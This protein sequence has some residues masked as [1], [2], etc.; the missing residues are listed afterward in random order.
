MSRIAPNNAARWR[1]KVRAISGVLPL[2]VW[3]AAAFLITFYVLPVMQMLLL[4]LLEP[5]PGLGNYRELF[6]SAVYARVLWN[7]FEISAQV[8][9]LCL[10]LGY[11][12]A[13]LLA[14]ASRRVANLLL[15]F[16]MIPF[17]TSMLVRTYAWI[18][19]LG[20]QGI[21]NTVLL[22]SGIIE[23]PL[24]LLYNRFGVL[25]G[26]VHVLLPYMILILYS[27]MRGIDPRLVHAAESLAAPPFT[28]F[29]RVYLPLSMPGVFCGCI[30]VFVMCLAFFIT[31]AMLGS[32]RETM[33]ANM[34]A[35]QVGVLNWGLG[36]ALS[37]ILLVLSLVGLFMVNRFVGGLAIVGGD[38][39]KTRIANRRV[40]ENIL[41]HTLDRLVDPVWRFVPAV[42]GAGVLAFLIVP[43]FVMLPLSVN[44]LTYFVFPPAGFTFHWYV[45][46]FTSADWME[47][48]CNSVLIALATAFL[49][50]VLAAPAALGITRS[51]SRAAAFLYGLIISPMIVPSIIVAISVGF[52][53]SQLGLIGT[54]VAVVLGHMIGALPLATVVLVSA[55]TNFDPNLERAS[56]SLAAGHLRTM[57]RVIL[58]A[59]RPAVLTGAF[60]A[61]L[62]S[63]DEL[64]IALFVSGMR[65]RTLPKKMWDSLQEIDPT[66]AAVSTILVAV[67][68][69]LV[70]LIQLLQ[71]MLQVRK[72]RRLPHA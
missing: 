24:R 1:A 57:L 30:L 16:V 4:S 53:F 60:F 19:L 41:T 59:I 58:P 29:R 3:P 52:V 46:Y 50:M 23:E 39:S 70:L 44:P 72:S 63:F 5:R 28:A 32:P 49:T 67:T 42:V 43:V 6:D 45:R 25:I 34:I 48:T 66:I 71:G 7:T 68:I 21:V 26:M 56:H 64:L 12:A 31:P 15:I 54:H 17:F 35:Y 55:L 22:Q 8:T 36:A 14:T 18:F 10:V 65:A 61:F 38:N 11:P 2:T 40:R 9:V 62:H 27:V 51:S 13:Y 20:W 69:V 33:I 37:V 47:A